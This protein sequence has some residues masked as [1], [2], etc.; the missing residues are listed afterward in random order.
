MT[1]IAAA[2]REPGSAAKARVTVGEM[3]PEDRGAV[4]LAP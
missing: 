3:N 4:Q 2:K 1:K